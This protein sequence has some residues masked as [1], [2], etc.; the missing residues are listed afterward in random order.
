MLLG[1]RRELA[2]RR[3]EA[4]QPLEIGAGIACR[5]QRA[6]GRDLH[7]AEGNLRLWVANRCH[8]AAGKIEP[9]DIDILHRVV[10]GDIGKGLVGRKGDD[11]PAAALAFMHQPGGGGIARVHHIKVGIHPIAPGRAETDEFAILA[12]GIGL[13]AALA[14]G[15]QCEAAIL[16]RVE[17]VILVPTAVLGDE[18]DVTLGRGVGARHRLGFEADLRARAHRHRDPVKLAD[19]GEAGTDQHRAGVWVPPGK[20]RA[21]GLKV[22]ADTGSQLK[23]NRWHLLGGERSGHRHGRHLGGRCGG[24]LRGGRGEGGAAEQQGNQSSV[25]HVRRS[26]SMGPRT[27]RGAVEQR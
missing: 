7:A 11:R 26:L 23:R 24:I 4:A 13:V 3:I 25:T 1:D 21:A 6:V 14:V 5:P 19:I 20:A 15:Q 18:D 16:E 22:G 10:I 9:V 27:R 8:R 2:R 17:L 12:P